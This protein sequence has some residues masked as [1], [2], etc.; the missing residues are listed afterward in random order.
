MNTGLNTTTNLSNYALLKPKTLKIPSG[1]I[2]CFAL[3]Y[4]THKLLLFT[5]ETVFL[6]DLTNNYVV[7]KLN[8]VRELG[9]LY[10]SD[11]E[12]KSV[13]AVILGNL[14]A[15]L[16]NKKSFM[17]F[18]DN[19][20]F[21]KIYTLSPN[22]LLSLQVVQRTNDL[23]TIREDCKAIKIWKFEIL[24]DSSLERKPSSLQLDRETTK[25]SRSKIQ[26]E[27]RSKKDR[28]TSKDNKEASQERETFLK[29]L[30]Q[31]FEVNLSAK[32]QIQLPLNR[33]LVKMSF[34]E[35]LKIIAVACDNLDIMLYSLNSGDFIHTIPLNTMQ[36]D[37]DIL[38]SP[39]ISI[40]QEM[41]YYCDEKRIIMYDLV[42]NAEILSLNHGLT[43]K[44][45]YIH[46]ERS[47]QYTGI[48][49]LTSD[50]KLH[51]FSLAMSKHLTIGHL[52]L[53]N[54]RKI[55]MEYRT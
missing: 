42:T 15:T 12:I 27:F 44:I 16:V 46:A 40:E 29:H 50:D 20:Q 2:I 19:L 38:S 23:L 7:K 34:T 41:L 37:R 32:G 13:D 39:S 28:G 24:D 10:D 3:N 14:W 1:S 21:S 17:F 53:I 22:F 8:Y 18:N 35:E 43:S 55:H 36:P 5:K 4:L 47:N 31:S 26:I 51:V 48:Y 33:F 6:Y 25:D 9:K 11:V 54:S 30:G 52:A 49:I 45:S